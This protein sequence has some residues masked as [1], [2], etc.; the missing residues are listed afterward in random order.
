MSA[1]AQEAHSARPRLILWLLASATVLSAASAVAATSFEQMRGL[2]LS[3][4]ELGLTLA[5]VL[6]FFT[7][8]TMWFTRGIYGHVWKNTSRVVLVACH[9]RA[10][11]LAAIAVFGLG[12]LA[13]HLVVGG[14]ASWLP[15]CC[16][17]RGSRFQA[18]SFT[19]VLC[20]ERT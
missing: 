12:P 7:S 8:L 9:V 2:R 15:D 18:G 13:V 10:G 3:P 6:A 5:L 11:I 1:D 17:D 19:T 14:S 20:G 16:W 4:L